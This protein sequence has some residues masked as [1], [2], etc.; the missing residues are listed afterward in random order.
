MATGHHREGLAAYRALV[1]RVALL[2]EGTLRQRIYVEAAML[3]MWLGPAGLNEALGYLGEAR[4]RDLPVGQERSVLAALALALDR[5][6]RRAE[7]EG[8]LREV[9]G[10]L[11]VQE[12]ANGAH[13]LAL[14]PGELLALSAIVVERRDPSRAASEWQQLV[15]AQPSSPWVAHAKARI[16]ALSRGRAKGPAE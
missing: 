10:A 7:A 3:A 9:G 13:R 8:V 6:G 1:P 14:P 5:Q 15:D 2:D 11:D 16:A 12:L 4:S